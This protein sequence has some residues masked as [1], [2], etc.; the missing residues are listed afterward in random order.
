[1]IRMVQESQTTAE[2]L[3]PAPIMNLPIHKAEQL[4]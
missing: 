2:S 4:G 3:T 1:M